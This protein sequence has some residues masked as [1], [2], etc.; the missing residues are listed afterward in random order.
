MQLVCNVFLVMHMLMQITVIV[1]RSLLLHSAA[2]SVVLGFLLNITSM[3]YSINMWT[4]FQDRK[5]PFATNKGMAV[6]SKVG[7]LFGDYHT[8]RF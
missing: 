4:Y 2:S 6:F 5:A 7:L 8:H 1:S 3:C